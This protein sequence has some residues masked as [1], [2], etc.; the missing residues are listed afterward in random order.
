[1]QHRQKQ[2]AGVK[3][4]MSIQ[5]DISK[6]IQQTSSSDSLLDMANKYLEE[7]N[8]LEVDDPR[9]AVLEKQAIEIFGE[10]EKFSDEAQKYLSKY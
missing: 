1:M 3:Q 2:T 5:K 9:K 4:A 6:V 8:S 7:A 10:A